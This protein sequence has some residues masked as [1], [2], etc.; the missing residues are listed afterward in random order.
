MIEDAIPVIIE[1]GYDLQELR[2][3]PSIKFTELGIKPAVVTVMI[4]KC[5]EYKTLFKQRQ[6]A[7]NLSRFA[8][9]AGNSQLDTQNLGEDEEEDA[10]QITTGRCKFPGR[11]P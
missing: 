4:D 9:G 10:S 8:I 11:G 2:T 3:L 5:S 7:E 1:S 6:A